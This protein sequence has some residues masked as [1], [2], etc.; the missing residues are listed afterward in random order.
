M[1]WVRS[2]YAGELAV[3]SAWLSALLPWSFTVTSQGDVALYVIR[4]PFFAFRFVYGIDLGAAAVPFL[5]VWVAP[6][7]PSSAAVSR[8]YWVW[9]AGAVFVALAVAL[10]LALYLDQERVEAGAVDPVRA[11][12]VLLGFAAVLLTYSFA[13]LW[14]NYFGLTLPVGALFLWVFAG[15]LLRVERA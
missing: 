13:S 11:M 7:F 2:E 5:P 6:G 3:L 4:F 15:V 1:V 8:A 10:S 14:N 9:L 12:G